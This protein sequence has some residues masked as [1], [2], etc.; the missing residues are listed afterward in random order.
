M[1]LRHRATAPFP[2]SGASPSLTHDLLLRKRVVRDQPSRIRGI[3][4][5]YAPHW[6]R[7]TGLEGACTGAWR[8]IAAPIRAHLRVAGLLWPSDMRSDPRRAAAPKRRSCTAVG[9]KNVD[10]TGRSKIGVPLLLMFLA[11]GKSPV[12][13]CWPIQRSLQHQLRGY[14]RDPP[15]ASAIRM[16]G[17]DRS[18]AT[19]L[20]GHGLFCARAAER[21]VFDTKKKF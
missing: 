19:T 2:S 6:R 13:S 1:T 16:N 11:T 12:A 8:V 18:R 10:I 7:C 4:A 14:S 21:K 9:R 15:C 3:N 20:R 17:A 5:L